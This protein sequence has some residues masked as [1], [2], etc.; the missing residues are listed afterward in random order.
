MRPSHCFGKEF[1]A[2]GF[3]PKARVTPAF[4]IERRLLFVYTLAGMVAGLAALTLLRAPGTAKADAGFGYELLAIT[5]V[6][7][8]APAFSAASVPCMER[9]SGS[10]RSQF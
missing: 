7:L 2:I 1:R 4:P 9:C 3:R 6:V 8:G 10:L 5:A